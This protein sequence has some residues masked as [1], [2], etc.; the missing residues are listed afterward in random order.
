MHNNLNTCRPANA[1]YRDPQR[2]GL[3]Q[4]PLLMPSSV[5][6]EQKHW[7]APVQFECVQKLP[8][9]HVLT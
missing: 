3:Q 8:T 2:I 1:R 5:H 9:R 4:Q 7:S 6:D